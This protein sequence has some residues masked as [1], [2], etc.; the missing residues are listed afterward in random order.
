MPE[1]LAWT[2]GA[3]VVD[4][5]VAFKWFFEDREPF[6]AQAWELLARHRDGEIVLCAPDLL[7]LEITSAL[8]KRGV[9]AGVMA[10]A[11]ALLEALTLGWARIDAG[12]TSHAAELAVR[13][14]ITVYDAT[15][16]ALAASLD[17]ELITDDRRLAGAGACRARLLG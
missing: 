14:G 12:L 5:S 15:Y 10:Q 17:C 6:V 9:D 4:A 16:A 3:F 11:C 1:R 2:T 13:H 7:Y 8:R